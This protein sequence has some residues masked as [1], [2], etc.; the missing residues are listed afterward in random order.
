[1]VNRIIDETVQFLYYNNGGIQHEEI[2]SSY[3]GDRI[4]LFYRGGKCF[5]GKYI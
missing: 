5:C 4:G 2:F 1:M 3:Y